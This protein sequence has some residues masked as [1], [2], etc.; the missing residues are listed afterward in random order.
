M[1]EDSFARF[2][3]AIWPLAP[4]ELQSVRNEL[5]DLRRVRVLWRQ[6]AE[7]V[8]EPLCVVAPANGAPEGAASATHFEAAGLAKGVRAARGANSGPV[9]AVGFEADGAVHFYLE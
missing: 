3:Q 6:P 1:P 5:P 9:G 8:H 4:K 7:G 2:Q